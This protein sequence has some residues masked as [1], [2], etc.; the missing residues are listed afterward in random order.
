MKRQVDILQQVHERHADR[1]SAAMKTLEQDLQES[2]EQ[3]E[4]ALQSH[5]I[6]VDTLIDLQMQRLSSL[7][8]MFEA[9]KNIL[10]NEFNTE[11]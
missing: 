6:N 3:Y 4:T 7:Q 11:R 1:K 2:E 8:K 10:E 5:L 9:D